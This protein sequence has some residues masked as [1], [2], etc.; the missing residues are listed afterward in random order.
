MY[1]LHEFL[2]L[3]PIDFF[4]VLHTLCIHCK[5]YNKNVQTKPFI[6]YLFS[7]K[8]LHIYL[9]KIYV[10]NCPNASSDSICLELSY[11]HLIR[12]QL[13]YAH[14]K[15]SNKPSSNT[16][17]LTCLQGWA[18]HAASETRYYGIKIFQLIKRKYS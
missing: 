15:S 5:I 16:L 9:S 2:F 14:R 17:Q 3:F 11:F 1:I 10:T 18:T 6:V 8:P 7:S 13:T 4:F 12:F